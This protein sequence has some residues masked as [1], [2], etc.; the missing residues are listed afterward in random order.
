MNRSPTNQTP[1]PTH[2][3]VQM[4][5][6]S[7]LPG[8][9]IPPSP[10]RP[11]PQPPTW[12]IGQQSPRTFF[13]G[14][15]QNMPPMPPRPASSKITLAKMPPL[16]DGHDKSRWDTWYDALTTYVAAYGSEFNSEATKIFFTLSLLRDE[17]GKA[18]PASNWVRNWKRVYLAYGS[19]HPAA[20]FEALI[21]E[22][23]KTFKD[24]N[25]KETAHLRLINTRQG[26]VPLADFLQSFELT[27][28]EAG[29]TPGDPNF[30][31]FLCQLLETLVSDEVRR[32]L[33][34]GGVEI[35]GVYRDL[36]KRM[37]VINSIMERGKLLKAALG[38]GN[39]F[40]NPAGSAKTT[41]PPAASGYKGSA[42]DRSKI[43][44]S[45]GGDA[46]DVDRAKT[47][48]GAFKCYNCGEEGHM[49]RECPKP[50]R[51]RGK[52]NVRSL[53]TDEISEEDYKFLF[54]AARAKYG[55]GF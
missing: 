39:M 55:Q 29:Y 7:F 24:Q 20:T 14:L 10:P 32:Q 3:F 34:A 5:D 2:Y 54:A 50:R 51:E 40:W 12:G 43:P 41:T 44:V 6:G 31:T 35:P 49:A 33:Y 28:E 45:R 18:C 1:P 15:F 19:L 47:K 30:D 21:R 25:V 52:L 53:R 37:L 16:F 11:L 22:L 36:K 38:Q 17:E 9:P 23:E 8:P 27:A 48:A 13:S 42:P 26:K 46:M 4:P